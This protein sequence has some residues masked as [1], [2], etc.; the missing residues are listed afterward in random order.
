VRSGELDSMIL[1]IHR[2]MQPDEMHCR[3]LT[4]LADVIA[5]SLSTIF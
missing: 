5:K 4:E 3:V 1:N 2:S